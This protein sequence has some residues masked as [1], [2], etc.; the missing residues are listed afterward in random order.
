MNLFHL[1]DV[2]K[3][4]IAEGPVAIQRVDQAHSVTFNVKYD[5]TESLGSND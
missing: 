2:A 3:I 4:E 5:S 1:G